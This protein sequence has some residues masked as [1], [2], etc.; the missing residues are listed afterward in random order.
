MLH[1]NGMGICSLTK[2]FSAKNSGNIYVYFRVILEYKIQNNQ[3]FLQA[4][5][6]SVPLVG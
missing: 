2:A 6:I 1:H 4:S 5:N 3:M